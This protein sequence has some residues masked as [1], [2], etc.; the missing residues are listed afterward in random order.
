VTIAGLAGLVVALALWGAYRML[1]LRKR[2]AFQFVRIQE[3]LAQ[4]RSAT[5]DVERQRWVIAAGL[6]L[7]SLGFAG[8]FL[9]AV[10]S[11]LIAF[12]M[13]L[14]GWTANTL[15]AYVLALSLGLL[16][17]AIFGRFVKSPREG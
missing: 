6:R 5:N 7:V 17:V 1:D 16:A 15:A 9:L 12:P 10:A 14:G 2:A 8:T 3:G 11:V 4:F 13:W